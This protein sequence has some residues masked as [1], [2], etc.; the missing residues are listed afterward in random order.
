MKT[1]TLTSQQ[2]YHSSIAA[3]ISPEDALD[4][5]SRVNE[6]WA[7]DFK[8]RAK[9]IGDTFTVHFGDTR[10][11]FKIAEAIPG[12]KVTWLVTDCWLPWLNDK[13]EWT[14]TEVVFDIVQ[15]NG[16]TKIDV[17]HV[18]LTPDI[19]CYEGCKQGWDHF[20]KVSLLKFLNG[21]TGGPVPKGQNA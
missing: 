16:L 15:E 1:A 2:D 5:I 6:W 3:G 17:T 11:D 13:H 21:G 9:N 7:L 20:I 10:V 4:K 14:G 12:K 8:G 19:E 18:G